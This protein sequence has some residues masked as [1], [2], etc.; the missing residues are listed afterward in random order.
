MELFIKV[1]MA[2]LSNAT[3]YVNECI[4]QETF[5]PQCFDM[6]QMKKACDAI[7]YRVR[8]YITELGTTYEDDFNNPDVI[9]ELAEIRWA[10][11]TLEQTCCRKCNINIIRNLCSVDNWEDFNTDFG[12][13]YDGESENARN[14]IM[15][16]IMYIANEIIL[17]K[18][19]KRFF[20]E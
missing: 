6:P 19:D 15:K 10:L 2:Y 14:N 11:K 16:H 20:G 1:G 3:N 18:I 7:V 5:F 8:E 12:K 9:I 17:N 4:N 13:C